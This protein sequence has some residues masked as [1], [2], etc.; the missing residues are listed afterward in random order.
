MK[1]M[2]KKK[3]GHVA[4]AS[5][6]IFACAAMLVGCQ[7]NGD[8]SG[9]TVQTKGDG[10]K[11]DVGENITVDTAEGGAKVQVGNTDGAAGIGVETNEGGAKV[12][13]GESITV[14]TTEGGAKVQ[15]GDTDEG[16]GIGVETNE[17][18]A[19]VDVGGIH[20]DT[21]GDDPVVEIP[22]IL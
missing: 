14:D 13:V 20:V 18:G 21:T 19:R 11:V 5:L 12:D 7:S 17:D 16:A 4:V 3:N 15:I 2:H 22:D 9:V 10:A 8:K 1:I 6:A